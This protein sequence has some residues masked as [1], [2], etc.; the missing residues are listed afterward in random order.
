MTTSTTQQG[1]ALA[2]IVKD[3]AQ[4]D[5]RLI[6]KLPRYTGRRD[7]PKTQRE[8]RE[9]RECGQYH[10]FP[11]IHLDYVGHATLTKMLIAVDP[12]WTWEPL[13][14]RDGRPAIYVAN[15]QAEMWGRLTVLGKTLIGVGTAPADKSDVSKELIGDFL[16]NAAMRFGFCVNLWSKTDADVEDAPAPPTPPDPVKMDALKQAIKDLSEPEAKRL[17]A[18]WKGARL[19]L[20]TELTDDH[21]DQVYALLEVVRTMTDG[22][23]MQVAEPA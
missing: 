1:D 23:T 16:R 19:P 10:E 11:S 15:G 18:L 5:E 3:Y 17:K 4:P 14:I 6:E 13:E 22:S 12:H 2:A 7:T 21:L 20:L 8:R 9:C